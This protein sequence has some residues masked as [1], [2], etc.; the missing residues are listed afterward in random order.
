MTLDDMKCNAIIP[1]QQLEVTEY[2]IQAYDIFENDL[3]ATESYT[4]KNNAEI[5]IM[6]HKALFLQEATLLSK[7]LFQ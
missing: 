2:R 7:A 1:K 4:A 3:D 5:T 6:L